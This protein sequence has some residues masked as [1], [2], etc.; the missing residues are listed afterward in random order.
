MAHFAE[1][2]DNNIVLRVLV[3][4]NEAIIDANGA[5]Q[6]NI[7]ANLCADLFGGRWVQTSYNNNFRVRYAG[8]GMRYYEDADGFGEAEAPY[9][10]WSFNND[11]LLFEPPTPMPIEGLWQWDEDAQ[12]WVEYA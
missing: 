4:D 9:P 12:T 6:E 8:I 7:G 3:V 11:T 5:E 2:D 1:L 10:S